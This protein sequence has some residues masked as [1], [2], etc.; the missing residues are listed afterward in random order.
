MA[1]KNHTDAAYGTAWS[2]II[3]VLGVYSMQ[4]YQPS[5]LGICTLAAVSIG[6][7]G[8]RLFKLFSV[9]DYQQGACPVDTLYNSVVYVMVKAWECCM[10]E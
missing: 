1:S 5:V 8:G 4:E 3:L 2:I 9:A 7:E 10:Y 6:P